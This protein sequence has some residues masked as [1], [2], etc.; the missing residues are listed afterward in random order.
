M[1]VLIQNRYRWHHY[2][3]DS[4]VCWYAGSKAVVKKFICN[5]E[6]CP[7]AG[8]QELSRVSACLDGNF[9]L[10][11]AQGTRIIAAVDKIRSY[12]IFYYSNRSHFQISNSARAITEKQ[13]LREIDPLSLIEF[14]M[15]GFVTGRETLFMELHQLQAGEMLVWNKTSLELERHRYFLFLPEDRL[16]ENAQINGEWTDAVGEH[17]EKIFEKLIH[18]AGDRPIWVPLSG[19]LDSR[20]ILCMLASKGY[21]NLH[22]FSYGVPGNYEA[23]IAREVA[24]RVGVPWVFVPIKRRPFRDFYESRDRREYWKF[25]DFLCSVPNMQDLFPIRKMLSG[26]LLS[27]D[28]IIVNGQSGD[29]ITGGHIPALPKGWENQWDGM[30]DA[31]IRKHCS[32]WKHSLTKSNLTR[33]LEKLEGE[34]SEVASD[35]KQYEPKTALYEYWEWQERQCKYVV[36]GQRVYDW[37]GLDWALPLWDSEYL[38]FWKDVPPEVKTGQRLYRDYLRR[39]DAYG[40]FKDFNRT[41]WRWP[42]P[43]ITVVPFAR[44]AGIVAGSRCKDAVYRMA[45]YWGH[46]GYLFAAVGFLRYIKAFSKARGPLSF[47]IEDW[48]HENVINSYPESC[49]A[50]DGSDKIRCSVGDTVN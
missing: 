10:I 26:Q 20:L 44:L 19:G 47:M 35:P 8:I 49:M 15:A 18:E 46:Y 41:V 16:G 42:G 1:S 24:H 5:L 23:R 13:K 48:I 28:A 14:R 29:F 43:M 36:N 30:V 9:A 34:L 45:S 21:S 6:E 32:Q 4:L 37:L 38:S 3:D 22:A 39:W 2:K 40:L 7:D 31:L 50:F 12:P 17:T 33:F 11:I 27:E 25:C